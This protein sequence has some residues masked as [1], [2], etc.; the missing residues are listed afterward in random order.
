MGAGLFVSKI[1]SIHVISLGIY[2]KRECL[3]MI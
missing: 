2:E 1:T 3:N